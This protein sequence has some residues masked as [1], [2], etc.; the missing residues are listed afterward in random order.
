M[1]R[2]YPSRHEINIYPCMEG[3]PVESH[4]VVESI[5][6]ADWMLA[7]TKAS[8]EQISEGVQPISF[9]INGETIDPAG[10]REKLI[11]PGDDVR[12]YPIP[13][14]AGAA[15]FAAYGAYIAVAVAAIALVYALSISTE[16]PDGNQISGDRLDLNPAK[17][18]GV[19]LYEPVREVLGRAKIY[20]DYALQ[21]VTRFVSTR[22]ARTSMFLVVGVGRF[23]IPASQ[24]KIGETPISAFGSEVS[25]AIYGPGE[26]VIND[27]RSEN[28]YSA[29]EV[30]ASKS[31]T[32]GL[33]LSS[34]DSTT[35]VAADAI[36]LTGYT[37]T[38]IG[39]NSA[40]P[41]SWQTGT[42]INLIAPD[43][44]TVVNS[45]TYSVISGPL[46]ELEPFVGML[47]T[48]TILA[49]SIP[50]VVASYS[51]YT[52]PVP[53]VGGQPSS[54]TASA[55]PTTYDFS[56]TP[57]VW[58]LTFRGMTRS[59]SLTANYS[60][61]SGVV[62]ELTSQLSGTGLVAQDLSGRLKIL[63]PSSPYQGGT[64]SMS[65]EPVAVFGSGPVYVTG[66]A[67]TGGTPEQ[68][69]QITLNYESG[70]PFTGIP[71]GM[72]R[73]S[74]GYRQNRY[75]IS[76]IV[77]GN[78]IVS[79]LNSSGSVDGS[80]GGFLD[81][82][83]L[84]FR[85]SA[86]ITDN[87]NWIGP[88]MACPEGELVDRIEWDIF[89][90]GGLQSTTSKGGQTPMISP[91]IMQ[92]AD[93]ETGEWVSVGKTYEANT[94]D[95]IGYTE[96]LTLPRLMRPMVRIRRQSVSGYQVV[97][98]AAQWYA[99]RGRLQDRP[100]RYEGVTCI[101]L[102]VR[103]G[104]RLSAQSDRQINL[105][106]T[107][108]YEHGAARS[109]SA[110]FEHVCNTLPDQE[111]GYDAEEL[112]ELEAEYWT[113]RGETFDHSFDK[114]VTVKEALQTIT[115]A[116][117]SFLAVED[118]MLTAIREGV[119]EISGAITPHEQAGELS[120][121]FVSPSADD[122]SGVDVKYIHPVTFAVEIVE[123]RIPGLD[124]LKIETLTL[125]GVQDRI[126][127]WR[128]GMRRLMKYQYQRLTHKVD[129]E[130]S[131]LVYRMLDHVVMTDDIPGNQTISSIIEEMIEID[132]GE[133]F[134]KALITSSE[135][136]DWSFPKPRVLIKNQDGSV[137]ALMTPERVGSDQMLLPTALID[138]N[139][140][141]SIEP[142]RMVFCSSAK[143]GY[144]AMIDSID[145]DTE[146]R[147]SVIAKQYSDIFYQYDDAT[148]PAA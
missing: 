33:D 68:L 50:L 137:S 41:D 19:K 22:D 93:V 84:D 77:D 42:I 71:D 86:T 135:E 66:T 145:P 72:H 6:I 115:A 31:A 38:P 29:P 104:S 56:G 87:A 76:S 102:T 43:T 48:L 13:Y 114:Q 119:R 45:G 55:A 130:L 109:I 11:K 139:V 120:T 78:I 39:Q 98:D 10:W 59:L 74:L 131:A 141:W 37:I 20:P 106:A 58:N 91:I 69:A 64:I 28:W 134:G 117:M 138:T 116:G 60:N 123:C 40:L 75:R 144:S 79:R 49:E 97:A 34:P 23:V 3:R 83:V 70:Q 47:V 12:I 1:I 147:C 52:P 27:P 61:M 4:P 53:G 81:R 124:P 35:A 46:E 54:V 57:I 143:V 122:Y 108:I 127:A 2:I 18:N 103:T 111:A 85:L 125:N 148:P 92:Y 16:S 44:F 32:A 89:F 126:R 65:S 7:N 73:L 112:A 129:T 140:D 26:S 133:H 101:A 24:I 63:E 113:P 30:G 90:P 80:W 67:S 100:G 51:P 121:S 142:P 110:A 118:S 9:D 62:N 146:G 94:R 99:L 17:A 21:P 105:V 95:G 88:F 5:T 107:R 96:A 128:I 14:A 82:T 136:L 15:F 132:S 25:Y 8:S 36:S